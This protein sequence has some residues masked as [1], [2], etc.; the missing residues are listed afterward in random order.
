MKYTKEDIKTGMVFKSKHQEAKCKGYIITNPCNAFSKVEF[1][2]LDSPNTTWRD[3]SAFT[4][5]EVLSHINEGTWLIID[6]TPTVPENPSYEI[7]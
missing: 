6:T 4:M 1:D 7:F 2:S 3:G 5:K